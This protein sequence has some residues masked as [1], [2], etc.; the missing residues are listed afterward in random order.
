M[1]KL[2]ETKFEGSIR[3]HLVT[4]VICSVIGPRPRETMLRYSM[5][6]NI[7]VHHFGELSVN[8][9]GEPQY[10]YPKSQDVYT[11]S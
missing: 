9:N 10:P 6:S 2:L 5:L 8:L 1:L 3:R 11:D 7:V 4:L